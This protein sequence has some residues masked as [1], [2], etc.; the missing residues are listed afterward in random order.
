MTATDERL[1]LASDYWTLATVPPRVVV[2]DGVRLD[3]DHAARVLA[4]RW[5]QQQEAPAL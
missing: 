5:A 4:A 1:S 2:R 3:I